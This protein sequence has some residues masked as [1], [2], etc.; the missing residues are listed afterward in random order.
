[1]S[2]RIILA[3]FLCAPLFGGCYQPGVVSLVWNEEVQLSDGRMV[4]TGMVHSYNCFD[5]RFK[6]FGGLCGPLDTTLTLNGGEGVGVVTQLFKGFHPMF[7]GEKDGIWYAILTGGYRF[8]NREIPGQ[9]WGDSQGPYGQLAIRLVNGQWQPMPLADFP[10]EFQR[11]NML[12]LYGTSEELAEFHQGLVTLQNKA[13]WAVKHPPGYAD[14]RIT[15]S[16]SNA[17]R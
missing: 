1:M 6:Q 12:L 15:R 11:P 8:K 9:D 16:K 2:R 10:I 14:I 7:L 3:A 17:T 4:V 13:D 5:Y